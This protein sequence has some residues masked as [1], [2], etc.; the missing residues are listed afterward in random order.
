[1]DE[2]STS[3]PFY[4][5]AA[6][7]DS[8]IK[9]DSFYT[10]EKPEETELNIKRSRFLAYAFPVQCPEEALETI[11]LMRRKHHSATHVCWAYVMDA[12]AE[13][14]RSNDDGEPSGTAGKPILGRIISAD[15]SFTLLIVVR[16]FGGV[17]LGT[18]GLIEAYRASAQAVLD[19]C[20]PIEIIEK[21]EIEIHFPPHL[22]GEVMRLLKQ[23][24]ASIVR[25][26]YTE[27]YELVVSLRAGFAAALKGALGDF[28]ELKL[29]DE[30]AQGQ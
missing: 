29:L 24:D 25:Q 21:T 8:S 3:S 19:L 20:T 26:G 22:M 18:S 11:T 23:F 1:M 7:T 13:E 5:F 12:R 2:Y 6:M 14:Q 17:K 28:Y 4:F 16:Y 9:G 27:G 15:L 10:I 30:I